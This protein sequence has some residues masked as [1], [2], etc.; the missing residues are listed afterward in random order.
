ML[1]NHKPRFDPVPRIHEWAQSIQDKD[2]YAG[3]GE[4]VLEILPLW[5]TCRNCAESGR[6]MPLTIFTEVVRLSLAKVVDVASVL[7]AI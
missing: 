3:E 4:D 2:W 1:F 7:Y 6:R 5:S